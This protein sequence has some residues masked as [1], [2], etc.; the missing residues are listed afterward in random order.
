MPRIA[1]DVGQVVSH[2]MRP[3]LR[4]ITT[5][6]GFCPRLLFALNPRSSQAYRSALR[7]PS[8]RDNACAQ[9]KAALKGQHFIPFSAPKTGAAMD[10]GLA[11]MDARWAGF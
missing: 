3:N 6:F 1:A 2:E 7:S 8:V 11:W 5:I 4:W 10:V 9:R